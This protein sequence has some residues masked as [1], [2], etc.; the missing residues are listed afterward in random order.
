MSPAVISAEIAEVFQSRGADSYY[1]EAVTQLQHALQ[2]AEAARRAGAD[3]EC[4]LAALLHDIGHMLGDNHA[5]DPDSDDPNNIGTL[6]HDVLAADWLRA[7]SFSERVIQLAAGHVAAKRY[8]VSTNPGYFDRLS[9]VSRQTLAL[10]GGPMTP[11]EI[12]E[13]E[14][15][16]LLRDMLRVRS[17]DEAAKDP[18]AEVPPLDYWAPMIERH[19]ASAVQ[20]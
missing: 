10:Q 5:D 1:G 8:L 9:P 11:A 16:P 12:R 17:W 20:A 13:F 6:D 14:T 15:N 4:I 3:D 18:N 19:L 2:A 7:R